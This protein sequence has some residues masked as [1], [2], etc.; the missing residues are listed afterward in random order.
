[1][2][3]FSNLSSLCQS[4]NENRHS[5]IEQYLRKHEQ[6]LLSRR[7][8]EVDEEGEEEESGSI[9]PQEKILTEKS[10]SRN[11]FAS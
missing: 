2:K 1:M 8:A 11:A 5:L 4:N 9:N 10:T 3:K 7:Y 6:F